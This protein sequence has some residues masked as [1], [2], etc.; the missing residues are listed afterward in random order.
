MSVK[1]FSVWIRFVRMQ[2]SPWLTLIRAG[3]QAL[4]GCSYAR[5]HLMMSIAKLNLLTVYDLLD[6]LIRYPPY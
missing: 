2:V 6:D 5:T 1:T 4:R 3:Y